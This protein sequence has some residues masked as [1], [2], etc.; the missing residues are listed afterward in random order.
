MPPLTTSAK[1]DETRASEGRD[2][3]IPKQHQLT[4]REI[5][6]VRLLAAGRSNK[7]VAWKLALSIRTVETHRSRIMLKLKLDSL[8]ALVHYAIRHG[9]VLV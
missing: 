3:T 6:I 4:P 9:I 2:S 5:Q 7:Q 8:V 1:A